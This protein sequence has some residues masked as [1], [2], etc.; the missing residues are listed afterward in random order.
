[1]GILHL[2]HKTTLNKY[3]GVSSGQTGITDDIRERLK[4]EIQT[5]STEQEKVGSLII[6]EMSIQAKLIYD[7]KLDQ[8]HG[9]NELVDE[10][11]EDHKELANSLPC[12]VFRGLSTK[13]RLRVALFFCSNLNGNQLHRA[14][15][16]VIADVEEVGFRIL[17]IV[18]D[19]SKVN[20][21]MFEKLCSGT[22]IPEIQHPLDENRKIFLS[23]DQSHIIKNVRSQ[24]L[25][26][27]FQDDGKEITGKHVRTLYKLQKEL[28]FSPVR[29]LTRKMVY[30]SNLEKMNVKRAKLLFSDPVT[31]A[32]ETCSSVASEHFVDKGGLQA[33]LRFMKMMKKWFDIHDICNRT[34]GHFSRNVDKLHF[35]TI[36]DERLEWLV[37]VFLPYLEKL[38]EAGRNKREKFST[39][40]Y[41]ALVVTTRSTVACIQYLLKIGF[42]YVLTRNFSSDDIEL[43]FSHLRQ[44][45]GFN[46]MMDARAC[47]HAIEATVKTG[48]L[49]ASMHA[50]VE[51]SFGSSSSEKMLP[52]TQISTQTPEVL[53]PN[54]VLEIL[55]RPLTSMYIL[56]II[57]IIIIIIIHHKH[58]INIQYVGL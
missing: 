3:L 48:L 9:K 30:P 13:Y 51:T 5:L 57:I 49:Q 4:A 24:F 39:E 55:S 12:F 22:V 18:T 27:T 38:Q 31:A 40:T 56:F 11:S 20:V 32:L 46:D 37:D 15:L 28:I 1:M 2:P 16:K 58:F 45:G 47:M 10:K 23:Y 7:R 50:N 14:T 6:D 19:N 33:T 26:K 41:C 34:Q 17:R 36:S 43:F 42:H 25:E 8:F 35:F 44:L 53:L 54:S 29:H 21:S 52:R